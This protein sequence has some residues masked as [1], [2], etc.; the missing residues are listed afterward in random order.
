[1]YGYGIYDW[2]FKYLIFMWFQ[3]PITISAQLVP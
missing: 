2:I 3:V 1:M